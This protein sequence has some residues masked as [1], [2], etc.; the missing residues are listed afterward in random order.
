MCRQ[1]YWRL[2]LR[3]PTCAAVSTKGSILKDYF[4]EFETIQTVVL[5]LLD[6]YMLGLCFD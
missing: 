6:I 4:K 2:E 3:T 1:Y 5:F